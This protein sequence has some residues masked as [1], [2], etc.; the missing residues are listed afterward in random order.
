[1]NLNARKDNHDKD[2]LDWS[3]INSGSQTGKEKDEVLGDNNNE[4]IDDPFKDISM[5]HQLTT[6]DHQT[7]IWSWSRH[8][9]QE[10]VYDDVGLYKG[11]CYCNT[12][13]M[14]RQ[15]RISNIFFGIDAAMNPPHVVIGYVLHV[16]RAIE[17]VMLLQVN[18]FIWLLV[19]WMW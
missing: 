1:M 11:S 4:N 9:N 15:S 12:N 14:Q 8:P 18:N 10:Y 16:V 2:M 17:G 6:F 5:S 13:T 19:T 7:Q 3:Y